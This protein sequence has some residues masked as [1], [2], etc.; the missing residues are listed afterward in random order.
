MAD[1]DIDVA[2]LILTAC[3]TILLEH[4]RLVFHKQEWAIIRA[5]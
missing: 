2:T 1:M 5:E 4:F 3:G